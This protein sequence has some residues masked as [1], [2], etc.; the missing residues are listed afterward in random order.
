MKTTWPR[1]RRHARA[2]VCLELHQAAGAAFRRDRRASERVAR[3][4]CCI[5][6][7]LRAAA[8]SP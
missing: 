8:T 2:H 4:Y 7:G 3:A 6:I 1:S 5:D